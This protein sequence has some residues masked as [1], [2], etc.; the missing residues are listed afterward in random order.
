MISKIADDL[1]DGVRRRVDE[2]FGAGTREG[3]KFLEHLESMAF[4][5]MSEKIF[6]PA[7]NIDEVSNAPKIDKPSPTVKKTP[8]VP[9]NTSS[10]VSSG[11]SV[12]P[13]TSFSMKLPLTLLGLGTLGTGA[14]FAYDNYRKRQ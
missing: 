1:L 2:V 14:Y 12:K 9:R 5:D 4:P 11:P 7:P 3:K 10:H 8:S 13:S 6:G